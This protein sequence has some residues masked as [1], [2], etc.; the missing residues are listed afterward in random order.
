MK[1]IMKKVEIIHYILHL[2]LVI[3]GFSLPGYTWDA[4]LKQTKIETENIQGAR[5]FLYSENAFRSGM[6]RCMGPRQVV[7]V[8]DVKISD[9]YLNDSYGL[10]CLNLYHLQI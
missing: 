3:L 2:Y 9:K 1:N 8:N 4:G 10:V 6:S 5:F 7:S